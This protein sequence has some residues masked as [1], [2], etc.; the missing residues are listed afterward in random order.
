[1]ISEQN[2]HVSENINPD[3][4]TPSEN[5]K[6][7]PPKE[8]SENANPS[9][10]HQQQSE[11]HTSP[12]PQ[13]PPE[14]PSQQEIPKNNVTEENIVS[15]STEKVISET[16]ETLPETSQIFDDFS[17][18]DFFS[19]IS[20]DESH[21]NSDQTPENYTQIVSVLTENPTPLKTLVDL[22]LTSDT[23]NTSDKQS[24]TSSGS[25][26]DVDGF[27]S[28]LRFRRKR[29]ENRF[30]VPPYFFSKLSNQK[31][32]VVGKMLRNFE[33]DL[34]T[35]LTDLNK[36]CSESYDPIE[37]HQLFTQFRERF[38]TAV[39]SIQ[40]VACQTALKNLQ[41][42]INQRILYLQ[43]KP[44]YESY[45]AFADRLAAAKATEEKAFLEAE[46]LKAE[47]RIQ[48]LARIAAMKEQVSDEATNMEIEKGQNSEAE[49]VVVAAE[50][51]I[52]AVEPEDSVD[53]KAWMANQEK[54]NSELQKST[55]EL[56][57]S[58][59][60]MKSWMVQQ[61]ETS[62]KIENLLAQLLSKQS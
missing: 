35:W 61:G 49:E 53:L 51:E 10:L 1:M 44:A 24:D 36:N 14:Q 27:L 50:K 28:D 37:A 2:I 21:L 42:K 9:E 13:N 41:E 30:V 19:G 34:K 16:T 11:P 39:A 45:T 43:E 48:E 18:T 46:I 23:N 15:E 25:S 17:K 52:K 31:K 54:V 58:S 32:P 7:E 8:S 38:N 29:S 55:A 6:S 12:S 5:T 40:D 60:E 20:V 47:Q 3:Q 56:Q 26:F 4:T 59:E 57:K 62:S 22:T 33:Y